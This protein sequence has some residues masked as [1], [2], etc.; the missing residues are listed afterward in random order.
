MAIHLACRCGRKLQVEDC[1]AGRILRCEVCQGEIDVPS[2]LAP[3]LVNAA[4]PGH[5]MVREGRPRPGVALPGSSEIQHE[6]LVWHFDATHLSL[7]VVGDNYL[8]WANEISPEGARAAEQSLQKTGDPRILVRWGATVLDGN[9]LV[10]IRTNQH[11]LWVEIRH[12][13]TQKQVIHFTSGAERDRFFTAA[14]AR[15]H[16]PCHRQQFS[17]SKAAM[18]PLMALLLVWAAALLAWSAA[19]EAWHQDL[20][21]GPPKADGSLGWLLHWMLVSGGPGKFI[22]FGLAVAAYVL[23]WMVFRMR[24][25]PLILTLWPPT[26]SGNKRVVCEVQ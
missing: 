9:D 11:A 14:A 5:E 3:G 19:V 1:Y 25:P 8:A 4:P 21:D 22:L 7:L 13:Q 10:E 2:F 17:R 26:A 15:L 18:A 23:A 12:H 16:L 6:V 20:H 24:R